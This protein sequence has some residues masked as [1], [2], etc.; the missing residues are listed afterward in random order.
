MFTKLLAFLAIWLCIALNTGYAQ[1]PAVKK[2]KAVRDTTAKNLKEVSI[3]VKKAFVERKTDRVVVNVDAL[4]SNAGT[5]ALDVLEKS[6]GVSIDQ[7]GTISL[8]G[9]QGV[10]IFIDDKPT[11]LSG[12][13]LQNYLQSLPSSSLEQIELMTNPPARYDAGGNA[14]VINIKTKKGKQ[15]GFN[16]GLNLGLTQGKL[17]SANQSFNFNYRSSK[18][19]FF[20]QLGDNLNNS[21]QDLNIYRTYKYTDGRTKS[22]F[23]QNS[24]YRG[25]GNTL[26]GK[27]GADYYQSDKTTW[28]IVFTGMTRASRL[29]KDNTSNLLN[30]AGVTDSIILANNLEDIDFKNTG[31]N[32]NYRHQYAAGHELTFDADYLAYRNQTRQVYHNFSYRPDRSLKSSDIL[33]G[34]LPA[35]VDI[36]AL[37]T[38]YSRP[39]PSGWK[40]DSGIKLSFTKTDNTADYFTT[41]NDLTKP[42]YDKSNHFIYKEQISA[43]YLNLTKETKKIAVQLGLRL[44]NTLS[45]G[46]QYGN[47]MKA[48]S[49]FKNTYTDLFPTLFLSWKPD[50][51]SRNQIG[52]NYGRRI[53]RPYY[54]DLNPFL[55]PLDKF[56][57]YL[58]NPFLKSAYTQS[59]ALSHTYKNKL[60]TTLSWSST[61]DQVNETIEIV[62][63]IYYSKPGNIG[64]QKLKSLSVDGDYE[65]WKWLN[66]QLFMQV[67]QTHAV[68]DFYTGPLDT[69][70]TFYYLNPTLQLRFNSAWSAELAGTYQ[71]KVV[72]AQ[73]ISGAVKQARA[74]VMKIISPQATL[75]LSVSDLF[76]SRVNSG[77]IR[78]LALTAASYN[79]I[80][81]SRAATLSF[82]YRFGKT[83]ANLRK[84]E[85]TGAEAEQNRVKN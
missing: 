27:A 44:E 51:L 37:K 1:Q 10:T 65:P 70:G 40:F 48:D 24:Y 50:T 22:Y 42:D 33:S 53:D 47:I 41:V 43:G 85:A 26:S 38:D 6:P 56:T 72:D 25:S 15:K 77:V 5:T 71:S 76:Y 19:N 75:K 3:S 60:T 49:A 68:S 59:I 62:N 23:N 18:V 82:S 7:N 61:R 46:H 58:G 14:G 21:F 73:F 13:D 28:G 20:G 78:N 35:N 32:I 83:I 64:T 79:G 54:Q 8:K 12:S 17:T 84:H 55:A 9:K 2:D 16:G 63:G 30:A 39:L 66:I 57:Y 36:Y 31:V 34:E 80:N 11:Y 67:A 45:D 74:A 29:T 52:L 81:D 4:I 69:K